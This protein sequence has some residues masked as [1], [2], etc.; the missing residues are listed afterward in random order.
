MRSMQRSDH[1][2]KLREIHRFDDSI[3]VPQPSLPT[4]RLTTLIERLAA[5]LFIFVAIAY[6]VSFNGKWR[7]GLDSANYRGLADSIA[8]GRGYVFGD[9]AGQNIYPGFPLLL[10]GLQKL[11]GAGTLAP[12]I[13]MLIFSALTMLV[14]YR[15]IRLH[16]PKWIAVTITFGV[17][18]NSW[19]LQQTSELMTDVPFLLGVVTSL[20]GWDLL[21]AT[22]ENS[23]RP[24]RAIA[25][26]ICGL[27]LSASMRPTF[28]ILVAAWGAVCGIGIFFGS[29]RSRGFYAICLAVMLAVWATMVALDPRSKGFHPLSGG[30]E[31]EAIDLLSEDSSWFPNLIHVLNKQL[32]AGFFGEQLSLGS[33]RVEGVK[34]SPS[35]IVG[36]IILIGS[37][38]LIARRHL[39]WAIFAW[40]MIATTVVYSDEPRYYLMILPILLLAWLTALMRIGQALPQQW[41]EMLLGAGLAVVTVNNMTASMHFVKEQ[42]STNFLETYRD[43][44]WLPAIHMAKILQ[45]KIPV[46]RSVLGPSGSVLS[47]LS[48][49]HVMTQRELLP[50]RGHVAEFPAIIH[51][52]QISYAIFPATLYRDKEPA[53]ARLME[54]G[55]L[56]VKK[57]IGDASGMRLYQLRVVVPE[58]DWQRLPK[59]SSAEVEKIPPPRVE[60]KSKPV[61]KKPAPPPR[62]KRKATTTSR[63]A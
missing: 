35:S 27:L 18:V 62:K 9:W 49:R 61:K 56:R 15:L 25:L 54:R 38:G 60:K 52:R 41:G 36:S 48:G 28:L 10:A 40:L 55:V 45:E 12:C 4:N 37:I 32:P 50:R 26:L 24:I 20:Y 31:R 7:I 1:A 19:F 14:T 6:L 39:L 23:G 58:S 13:V 34:Y 8:S 21:R 11:F 63:P 22:R 42:R 29:R 44:K 53:L 47:Y 5:P 59:L 51:D 3:A 43:G 46:G 57:R 2:E 33:I 30:Y 17:A 16:Y